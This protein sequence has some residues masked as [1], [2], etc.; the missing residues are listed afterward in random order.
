[1]NKI[2]RESYGVGILIFYF[3]KWPYVIGFAY[4]YLE[5]GLTQNW[6][7]NILWIYCVI[8][9][10]KDF[11]YLWRNG[12]RCKNGAVMMI[13]CKI[14]SSSYEKRDRIPKFFMKGLS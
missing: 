9:I 4:L 5:K 8:L 7:L 1:M 6:F 13:N 12:L 14:L 3:L 10:L 2:L 11:I